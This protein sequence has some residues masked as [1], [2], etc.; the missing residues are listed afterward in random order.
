MRDRV[1]P[2]R[3][4]RCA[5]V[6]VRVRAWNH[7]AARTF[8]RPTR[9]NGMKSERQKARAGATRLDEEQDE[10]DVFDRSVSVRSVS[11]RNESSTDGI[12]TPSNGNEKIQDEPFEIESAPR[13]NHRSSEQSHAGPVSKPLNYRPDIDGLRAVAVLAVILF[14]FDSTWLPGGFIGVDIFFV[15]SGYVVSGSLLREQHASPGAFL[16]AFYARR[17]KRLMPALFATELA[18]SLMISAFI[19][20]WVAGLDGY[21]Q[22]GLWALIGWAN[23]HFANLP[24]GYFDEGPAGLQ[25]NPFTQ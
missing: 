7:V 12:A 24:T 19:P 11:V 20:S 8:L 14:H 13:S 6:R 21:W 18:T 2:E 23:V 3:T 22:S 25:F 17:V 16:A 4:E 15:I 9:S 1:G 10:E 5:C